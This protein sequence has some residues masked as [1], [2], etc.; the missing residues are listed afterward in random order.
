MSLGKTTTYLGFYSSALSRPAP[1]PCSAGSKQT[2]AIHRATM[3]SP[4][5]RLRRPETPRPPPCP[6]ACLMGAYVLRRLLAL[7]ID[8][9]LS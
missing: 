8:L 4:P 6:G 3:A 9:M 1:A 5:Q 7:E 2:H